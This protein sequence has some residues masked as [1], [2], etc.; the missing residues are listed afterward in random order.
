M[1]ADPEVHHCLTARAWNWAMGHGD[2]VDAL[3]VV[4]R[5]VTTPLVDEL[6]AEGFRFKPVLRAIFTSDDFVRY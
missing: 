5:A 1:A 2:V 6:S 3:A 4:P